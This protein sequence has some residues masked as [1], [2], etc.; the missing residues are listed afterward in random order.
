MNTY[1][2]KVLMGIN[3][4]KRKDIGTS[5]TCQHKRQM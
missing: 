4:A 3:F 1:Q 5:G 2:E